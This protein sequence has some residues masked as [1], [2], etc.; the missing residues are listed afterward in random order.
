[1]PSIITS[2]ENLI[3]GIFHTITAALGSILAVFQ[4]LFNAILGVISTTFAAVGTTIKGLAQTFEGLTKFLLG[5]FHSCLLGKTGVVDE[6]GHWL[7][8]GR[9]GNI[10]VIGGLVAAFFVYSVYQQRNGRPVAGTKQKKVQ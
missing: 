3:G 7:T 10:V 9:I 4:G 2:I 6:G 5:M 1:M 8:T